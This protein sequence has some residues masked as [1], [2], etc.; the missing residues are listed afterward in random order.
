[1]KGFFKN[2][3]QD[4]ITFW[5]FRL[6]IFFIITNVFFIIFFY[7]SLPPFLPIY[8]KMPWGYA[9]LGRNYELFI[10]AGL[11]TIIFTINL[12]LC[13]YIYTKAALLAR[14]LCATTVCVCLFT[15]IFTVQII[16][17]VK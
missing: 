3:N 13:S 12:M 8:N 11:T 16:L 15:L 14:L 10:P 9:R 4:K 17:L 6:S 1:M 5:G 2:I 7:R